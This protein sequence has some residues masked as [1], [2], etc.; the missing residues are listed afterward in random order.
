MG[1]FLI[2]LVVSGGVGYNVIS[3]ARKNI[4][5]IYLGIG[6]MEYT[7]AEYRVRRYCLLNAFRLLFDIERLLDLDSKIK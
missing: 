6:L 3:L 1:P 4:S 7:F 2:T 5:V